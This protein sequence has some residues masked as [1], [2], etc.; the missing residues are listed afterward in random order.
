MSHCVQQIVMR[1]CIIDQVEAV[2]KLSLSSSYV[3]DAANR[4]E[5]GCITIL[6]AGSAIRREIAVPS[7]HPSVG[8]ALDMTSLA[9]T[10]SERV[11]RGPPKPREW[12]LGLDGQ[13]S[14][15]DD[16]KRQD[17]WSLAWD[18]Y[19][20]QTAILLGSPQRPTCTR[21]RR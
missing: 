9:W 3:P 10:Q 2:L 16:V 6:S 13:E 7:D 11:R 19:M 18:I 8:L 12:T 14:L 15:D 1:A 20:H 5:R 21:V 4:G 17:D